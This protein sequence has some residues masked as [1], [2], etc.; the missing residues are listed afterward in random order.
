MHAVLLC[1]TPVMSKRD[2]CVHVFYRV[3]VF[4]GG[5]VTSVVRP[6]H[7]SVHENL[8]CDTYSVYQCRITSRRVC[9]YRIGRVPTL[10]AQGPR[11]RAFYSNRTSSITIFTDL[12]CCGWRQK[13]SRRMSGVL[14][15]QI[16]VTRFEYSH[17]VS[18]LL[19][20]EC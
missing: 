13:L 15:E 8:I 4:C 18:T 7:L 6:A 14:R 12:S 5:E 3:R 20:L 9:C 2:D 11:T 10:A 19:N 17:S 16:D 1:W